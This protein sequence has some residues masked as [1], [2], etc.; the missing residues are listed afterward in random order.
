MA[1]GSF[2]NVPNSLTLLR[3][4]LVPVVVVLLNGEVDR[5]DTL[6][7]FAIF[8]GAMFTDVLDGWIARKWDLMSAAG[9]FLDPLADKLMVT[10]ALVMLVPLGWLPAWLVVILL[11]R[12]I[13]ITGLRGIAAQEGLT[14]AAGSMGKIK[15][16]FQTVALGA[17]LYHEPVA[18]IDPQPVGVVLML[19]ATFFAL[20]SAVEYLALFFS[21]VGKNRS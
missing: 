8:L 14:L 15:T 6:A 11:C 5:A 12:E 4:A 7:A 3:I 16:A 19:I 1:A 20:S 17:L 13:A 10:A 21:A 18:G 9:A 2:W